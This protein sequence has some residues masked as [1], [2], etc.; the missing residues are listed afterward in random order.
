M[1]GVSNGAGTGGWRVEPRRARRMPA[2]RRRPQADPF[3]AGPRRVR[4][5]WL[6]GLGAVVI[7]GIAVAV[8]AYGRPAAAPPHPGAAKGRGSRVASS[9]GGTRSRSASSAKRPAASGA[10]HSKTQGRGAASTTR[11][12]AATRRTAHWLTLPNLVGSG[13]FSIGSLRVGPGGGAWLGL[14]SPAGAYVARAAGGSV[15]G[16]PVAGYHADA[17]LLPAGPGPG[18]PRLQTA[19]P[20]HVWLTVA[21]GWQQLSFD[22]ARHTFSAYPGVPAVAVATVGTYSVALDVPRDVRGAPSGPP[23]VSIAPIGGTSARSVLLPGATV[24]DGSGTVLAGA[25][26]WAMVVAGQTVWSVPLAGGAAK[27]WATLP[28][29]ADAAAAAW[30]GG[31]LWFPQGG[32]VDELAAGGTPHPLAASRAA[33][34]RVGSRLAWSGGRLWWVGTHALEAAAPGAASASATPFPAGIAIPARGP[35]APRVMA[36]PGGVFCAVG[37]RLLTLS[38]S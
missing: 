31:R 9:A 11:P 13:H 29:G 30:G 32:V 8:F 3:L 12:P 33:P 6:V 15:R 17:H 20:H 5:G 2:G 24:A 1:R 34:P 16:W 37:N 22:R 7:A 14:D 27:V 25:P 19:G 21:G 10:D 23:R 28:A 26:G 18:A 35:G 36:R 38:A 4:S